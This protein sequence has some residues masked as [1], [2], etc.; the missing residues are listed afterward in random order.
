LILNHRQFCHFPLSRIT[1]FRRAHR[2]HVFVLIESSANVDGEGS[3][4]PGQSVTHGLA[5][6]LRPER[7]DGHR[8]QG[9][10]TADVRGQRRPGA[11]ACR[12]LNDW[13]LDLERDGQGCSHRSASTIFGRFSR[14]SRF[15]P[16]GQGRQG[17]RPQLAHVYRDRR[18]G[19]DRLPLALRF[20]EYE[21]T[22]RTCNSV[23]APRLTN[24]KSISIG[25]EN[26]MDQITRVAVDLAKRMIQVLAVSAPGRVRPHSS[27]LPT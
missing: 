23:E 10:A 8:S 19:P 3:V 13:I 20:C 7:P 12:C 14:G 9:S 2:V 16:I 21:R 27:N 22:S 15:E 25:K 24:G 11:C 26:P 1:P 17:A 18:L 5:S 4:G 6:D